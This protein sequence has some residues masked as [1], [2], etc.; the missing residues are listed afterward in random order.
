MS[1]VDNYGGT[2][3]HSACYGG[4]LEIVKLLIDVGTD[5]NSVNNI[6]RTPLHFA[7]SRG[8]I[9]KLLTDNGSEV[10]AV[11]NGADTPI[12]SI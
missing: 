7:C 8:N 10:N 9:V 4:H 2:I 11:G 3:F 6:G 5:M 1:A 12:H